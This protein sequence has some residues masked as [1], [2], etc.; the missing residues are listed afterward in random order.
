MTYKEAYK[1][2]ETPQM[3]I[4]AVRHDILVWSLYGRNPDRI[5]AIEKALNEAANEKGWNLERIKK[6]VNMRTGESLE[7]E[8]HDD[9][10]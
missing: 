6:C 3:L 7:S 9:D 2:T 8:V 1:A 4:D 5:N 10:E